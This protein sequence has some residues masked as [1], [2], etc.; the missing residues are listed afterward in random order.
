LFFPLGG[1]GVGADKA[2]NGE[3]GDD[4]CFFHKRLFGQSEPGS[5]I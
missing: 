5:N 3:R 4:L 2:E 1:V